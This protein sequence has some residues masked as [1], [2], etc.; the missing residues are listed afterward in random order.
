MWRD[1]LGRRESCDGKGRQR[2]T[3][4]R[5]GG[6]TLGMKFWR[7]VERDEKIKEKDGAREVLVGRDGET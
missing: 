6:D 3:N 2:E 5:G 1:T 7:G 4:R